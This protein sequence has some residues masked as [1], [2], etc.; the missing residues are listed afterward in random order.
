MPTM[1][2]GRNSIRECVGAGCQPLIGRL[3]T[4]LLARQSAVAPVND[5]AVG[6]ENDWLLETVRGDVI[7][8]RLDL[9]GRHHWENRCRW[10]RG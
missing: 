10:V 6:V 5:L 2:V 1:Q 4:E 8:E 7:A 9:G 3:Y